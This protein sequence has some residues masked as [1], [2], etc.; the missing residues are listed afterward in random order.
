MPYRLLFHVLSTSKLDKESYKMMLILGMVVSPIV[1]IMTVANPWFRLNPSPA[2]KYEIEVDQPA[3]GYLTEILIEEVD[4]YDPN[5]TVLAAPQS[6]QVLLKETYQ[7]ESFFSRDGEL[8]T[9]RR[10][11]IGNFW[12]GD[13]LKIRYTGDEHRSDP[14]LWVL[15]V[16][17]NSII[18]TDR[19]IMKFTPDYHHI[20]SAARMDLQI[21]NVIF[22][23]DGPNTGTLIAVYE[24]PDVAWIN[25]R[26][27][28]QFWLA[29][30]SAV[31][32]V[33][34]AWFFYIQPTRYM[35]ERKRL[36]Q[37]EAEVKK[38]VKYTYE[39]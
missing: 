25:R 29:G 3:V 18:T 35:R 21:N 12:E 27:N 37:K 8:V 36:K 11:D 23:D 1:L 17:D 14:A 34:A 6:T 30:I 10:R 22:R 32:L 20:V 19:R 28:F 5:G 31:V 26:R 39:E 16:G 4:P 2:N 7:A 38:K 9:R 33:F 13:Y 15:E 24:H